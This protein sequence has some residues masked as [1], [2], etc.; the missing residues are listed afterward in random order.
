MSCGV[1]ILNA[2]FLVLLAGCGKPPHPPRGSAQSKVENVAEIKADPALAA[3]DAVPYDLLPEDWPCWRGP[4]QQ[5]HAQ[6]GSLPTKFSETENV[7]WQVKVP[8]RGHASPIVTHGMVFL[9]T[10]DE[11]KQLQS[12]IAYDLKT[13][14]EKW[15]K[16]VLEGNFEEK[17]NI[18]H[19][20]THASSTM[21]TDGKQVYA[22]FLND[23][24]IHV[25]AFDLEGNLKWKEVAAPYISRFGFAASLILHHN[26][27]ILPIEHEGGGCM[28]ALDRMTGKI[29]WRK[30]RGSYNSYQ[31]PRLMEVNNQQVGLLSGNRQLTAFNPLNGEVLYSLDGITETHIGTIINEGNLIAVSG[32]YPGQETIGMEISATTA[33]E[34]WRNNEKIYIPSMLVHEGNIYAITDDGVGYSWNLKTGNKNWKSRV[35]GS[36]TASPVDCN[37]I[38]YFPSEQGDVKVIKLS[39][40]KYELLESC[41]L[42]DEIHASPAV[43][44]N[45]LLFRVSRKEKNGPQEYLIRVGNK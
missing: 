24:A 37:G 28:V 6:A 17:R 11:A 16:T 44:E 25:V 29:V 41:M 22:T 42:G 18:H 8:G 21:V 33:K 9:A 19:K 3:V 35:T 45:T 1:L 23:H 39:P 32:G 31:T 34:I 40:E 15:N 36:F 7:L 27:V 10:A 38:M 4:S 2:V 20:S 12:V 13:G 30:N 26:L 14:E 5:G 43:V